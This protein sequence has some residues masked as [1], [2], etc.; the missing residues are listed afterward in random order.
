VGVHLPFAGR[1]YQ[2]GVTEAEPPEAGLDHD[3]RVSTFNR[4]QALGVGVLSAVGGAALGSG[5]FALM[6]S[7]QHGGI[8]PWSRSDPGSAPP[9]SG[10][11]LQFGADAATEFVA[12]WHT[13]EAVRNP[14]VLLG[15]P[16]SGFGSTAVADTRVYRDAQCAAMFG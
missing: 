5:A 6:G 11:H 14:R 9:V 8:D 13:T 7:R 4:R 1:R 10:L 15:T 16:A 12:S 3:E 2:R